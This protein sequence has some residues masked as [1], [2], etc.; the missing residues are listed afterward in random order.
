MSYTLK[1]LNIPMLPEGQPYPE[2][3]LG[4]AKDPHPVRLSQ[5]TTSRSYGCSRDRPPTTA[6]ASQEPGN[7]ISPS[8]TVIIAKASMSLLFH[9]ALSSSLFLCSTKKLADTSFMVSIVNR[10]GSDRATLLL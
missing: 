8:P 5:R 4:S 6:N 9:T 2:H 10:C 7:S 3:Y 1:R